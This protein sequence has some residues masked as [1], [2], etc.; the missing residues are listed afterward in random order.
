MARRG[1]VDILITAKDQASR[2]IRGAVS[3]LRQLRAGA[4]DAIRDMGGIR[5]ALASTVPGRA[6]TGI[7]SFFS[8]LTRG[9]RDGIREL[10]GVRGAFAGIAKSINNI[11]NNIN[12][13]IAIGGLTAAIK[14]LGAA[15]DDYAASARRLE[16]AA[17][18]VGVP[19]DFMTE[20][21]RRGREEFSL[22]AT[23]ANGYAAELVTLAAKTGDLNKAWEVLGPTLNLGAAQGLKTAETLELMARAADGDER[24]TKK[25]FNLKA[26]AVFD[27]YAASIGK[28]AE[29]LT[30]AEKAMAFLNTVMVKGKLVQG[31]YAKF[32]ASTEGKLDD[33]GDAIRDVSAELG[34]QLAPVRMLGNQLLIY[35]LKAIN[36]VIGALH[37][38]G[39]GLGA[40]AAGL[41]GYFK[42]I[43][44]A[45]FQFFGDIASVLPDSA[46]KLLGLEGLSESL[47][48][49]GKQLVAEGKAIRRAAQAELD[50]AKKNSPFNAD[51]PGFD[52]AGVDAANAKLRADIA[53]REKLLRDAENK[54]KKKDI[55]TLEA[56]LGLIDAKIKAGKEEEKDRTRLADIEKQIHEKMKQKNLTLQEQIKLE[57]L[58]LQIA[59]T[60]QALTDRN[61]GEQKSARG[62]RV[63]GDAG[64]GQKNLGDS[65]LMQIQNQDK[66]GKPTIAP[67]HQG[68]RPD[69]LPAFKEEVKEAK[70]VTDEFVQ[71]LTDAAAG[72]IADFFMDLVDGFDS[73]EDAVEGFARSIMQ[74]MAQIASQFIAK[75]LL[76]SLFGAALGGAGK[77]DGGVI[78]KQGYAKGGVVKEREEVIK[79]RGY[80]EGGLVTGPGGPRSDSVGPLYLS[81]GEGVVTAAAMKNLGESGL[82]YINAMGEPGAP[83]TSRLDGAAAVGVASKVMVEGFVGIGLDDGL[84]DRK[85]EGAML[86][87]VRDKPK[88]IRRMLGL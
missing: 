51:K 71:G 88:A 29:E 43:K 72:P 25:L 74:S 16:G 21:A 53:R 3:Q 17:N 63:A 30:D 20:L 42:I 23:E 46:L 73:V 47:T 15:S 26:S 27:E 76:G 75:S 62:N 50:A 37:L 52:Q 1:Q 55:E 18:L 77:K 19:L 58:L 82:N 61:V 56:E 59:E 41:V 83:Q 69:G 2:I 79:K 78:K 4:G 34:K 44:G 68:G 7:R 49:E 64:L 70:T 5:N 33:Q 87:V 6:V 28:T 8:E 86:R 48:K 11:P 31:E 60:R 13:L 67:I 84:I 9:A 12:A 40:G 54:R 39:V 24:A 36:A 38:L 22:D 14:K 35:L 65:N 85:V 10:G 57:G 32:V 45:I 81:N 80:A 66:E